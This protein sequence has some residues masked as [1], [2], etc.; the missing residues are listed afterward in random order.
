MTTLRRTTRSASSKHFETRHPSLLAQPRNI[1]SARNFE[2]ALRHCSGELIALCDQ[3]DIWLPRR[4][5]ASETFLLQH[6]DAAF[7]FTDGQRI[8]EAG[9][10]LAETLWQSFHFDRVLQQQMVSGDYTVLLRHRF[11]TGASIT[12]RAELLRHVLPFPDAWVHDEW[13]AAVTPFFA[14]IGMLPE[15]LIQYRSHTAQQVGARRKST[16]TAETHWAHIDRG[17]TQMRD[18]LRH[19]EVHPPQKHHEL[20]D[21]YRSRA[22]AIERRAA[23]PLGRM[24]RTF[25][26]AKHFAEYRTHA[27]GLSSAAKDILLTKPELPGADFK[28][29][30]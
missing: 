13:L 17:R 23:L 7:V 20:Q 14:E 19:L 5:E 8:D 28:I 16:N 10:R 22:A 26:V 29:Q 4:L 30:S 15:Q 21:R 3:D 25:Q 12:L 9:K 27:A 18:L 24:A 1:G 2:H 11:I 6:P